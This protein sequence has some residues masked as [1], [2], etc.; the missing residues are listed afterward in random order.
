MFSNLV[1]VFYQ[2]L[3][4]WPVVLRP[5]GWTYFIMEQILSARVHLAASVDK[6][7]IIYINGLTSKQCVQSIIMTTIIVYIFCEA[8][9]LYFSKV[10]FMKL[11]L[12]V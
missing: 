9:A 2:F 12:V 5:L 4:L 3:V 10:T 6:K 8:L 1:S 7:S 11:T